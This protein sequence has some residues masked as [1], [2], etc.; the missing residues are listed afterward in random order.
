[1][2][3]TQIIT[4]IEAKFGVPLTGS[5]LDILNKHWNDG[6][7]INT[8][9]PWE[10]ANTHLNQPIYVPED[11]YKPREERTLMYRVH[12][13][14]IMAKGARPFKLGEEDTYFNEMWVEERICPT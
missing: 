7:S 5:A 14:Q 6:I 10:L 1:M 11:S 9:Q 12:Q 2:T 8:G 13:A 4:L 3:L